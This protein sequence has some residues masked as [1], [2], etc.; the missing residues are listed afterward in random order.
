[1]PRIVLDDIGGPQKL[2]SDIL[3]VFMV[4]PIPSEKFKSKR[5]I[6]SGTISVHRKRMDQVIFGIILRSLLLY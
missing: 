4:L 1:M 6:L 3:V 5:T 2:S